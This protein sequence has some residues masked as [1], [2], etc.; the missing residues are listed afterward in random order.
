MSQLRVSY[1]SQPQTSLFLLL[2]SIEERTFTANAQ[3]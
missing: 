1:V 3:H 2:F